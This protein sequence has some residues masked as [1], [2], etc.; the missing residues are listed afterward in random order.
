VSTREELNAEADRIFDLAL[1]KGLDTGRYV[2][3]PNLD[4]L[5]NWRFHRGPNF[6]QPPT[7]T[8][9]E[10]WGQNEIDNILARRES[11]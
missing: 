2:V 6:D 11:P 9:H 7:G 3:R 10:V 1:A 4:D 5:E 8:E